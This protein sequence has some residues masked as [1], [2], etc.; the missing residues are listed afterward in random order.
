[1]QI[2]YLLFIIYYKPKSIPMSIIC[3]NRL[4]LSSGKR[5]GYYKYCSIERS[6]ILEDKVPDRPE[7]PKSLQ[8]M[9][10]KYQF[11]NS[12][13]PHLPF[14]RNTTRVKHAGI[15]INSIRKVEPM[16]PK[17]WRNEVTNSRYPVF[18]RY[19]CWADIIFSLCHS[20][21]LQ[22]GFWNQRGISIWQYFDTIW[23]YI[24]CTKFQTKV[25]SP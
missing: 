4:N 18:Q 9:P 15:L 10:H 22:W 25:K 2:Y 1:M 20:S 24:P 3:C 13:A 6:P 11:Q 17:K 16:V 14:A 7:F 12:L 23:V 5:W 8:T 19:Q 21:Y